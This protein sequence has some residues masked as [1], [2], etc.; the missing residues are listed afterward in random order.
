MNLN[1]DKC[2]YVCL[3]KIV[4]SNSLQFF[5]ED[6]KAS[7]LGAGLGIEIVNKLNFKSHIQIFTAKHPKN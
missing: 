7:E 5:G 2:H 4:V 3:W 1:P 6:I